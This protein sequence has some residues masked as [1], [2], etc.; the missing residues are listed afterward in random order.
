MRKLPKTL[1]GIA[2]IPFGAACAITTYKLFLNSLES[3][4]DSG[5]NSW[6]FPLGFFLW[7]G[8]FFILPRPFRTY[9]L[10][11][12]LTHALWAFMMGGKT[13][14]I[15]VSRQGG[16]VT[17]SKTNF[18]IALAPYFFPFYTML[19]IGIYYLADL[20]LN[21][22]DYSAWWLAAIG[23]TW[24]FHITFTLHVLSQ[25]QPDIKEH[26]HIFSYSIIWIMNILV[27]ASLLI[28]LG[29]C[30]FTELTQGLTQE[31]TNAYKIVFSWTSA[32]R[33]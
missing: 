9:V 18:L 16:H 23:V 17:L 15:K 13:K 33:P 7:I 30:N 2:L 5:R 3:S 1:I 29:D 19:T 21:V 8:A 26:G 12:E 14:Q 20:W 25:H 27:I 28:L 11:H 4:M 22:Q 24:A 32:L 6:A 31:T 10:G